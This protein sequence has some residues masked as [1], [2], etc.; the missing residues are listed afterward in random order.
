MRGLS[1]GLAIALVPPVLGQGLSQGAIAQDRGGDRLISAPFTRSAD[2]YRPN[3]ND[4]FLQGRERLETEV[5]RLNQLRD[6]E[7]V[8]KLR[9]ELTRRDNRGLP[10]LSSGRTIDRDSAQYCAPDLR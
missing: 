6:S 4:F 2:L 3:G 7:S 1:V 9:P 5:E 10:C 8:L